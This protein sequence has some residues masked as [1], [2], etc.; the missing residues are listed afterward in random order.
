MVPN[1]Q[2]SQHDGPFQ[3]GASSSD[4]STSMCHRDWCESTVFR[5]PF[6]PSWMISSPTANFT[7]EELMRTDH[8][9]LAVKLRLVESMPSAHVISI[10]R[11][12]SHTIYAK[13]E[14]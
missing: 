7:S 1:L 3:M 2:E 4:C 14:M 13:Q 12:V 5:H 10:K 11:Y 6:P 9:F 8:E